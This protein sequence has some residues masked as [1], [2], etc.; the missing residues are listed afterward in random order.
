[1]KNHKRP[2]VP[3]IV[4]V[5]LLILGL[6]GWWW[7]SATHPDDP[8]DEPLSGRVEAK[9]FSIGPAMAGR[10]TELK[11]AEGD[12]V[13]EGQVL[14][15]LDNRAFKLQLSQAKQGVRAAKAAVTNAEDDGTKADVKAAKARLAQAQAAVELARVQLSYATIRAPRTGT[16][17]SVVGNAGQNAAPGRTLLTMIDQTDLFVRVFVPETRM[18]R[19]QVGQPANLITDS[20]PETYT[21]TI[22]F[23]SDQAEFTPNAI[24]TP[25]QRTKLVFEVR[26]RV[27]EP[28]GALKSGMSV[29]L[30]L[31]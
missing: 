30:W 2:P 14:V 10:I 15:Q 4:L 7:W 31:P 25:E 17:V 19:A 22:S 11:A 12:Q 13:I 9:E 24:D 18:S 29:D 27:D 16:I 20:S 21:G 8:F 3:V 23:V 5:A 6:G 1:M 26:V 28:F